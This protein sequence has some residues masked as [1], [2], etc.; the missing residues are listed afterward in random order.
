[1]PQT[2]TGPA[3]LGI[4]RGR[5]EKVNVYVLRD[6]A[7]F[8]Q[9]KDVWVGALCRASTAMKTWLKRWVSAG[10]GKQNPNQWN[11]WLLGS[12]QALLKTRLL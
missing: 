9:T 1:M 4:E 12:P 6:W 11:I 2:Y 8:D 7:S 10:P 3:G 5:A